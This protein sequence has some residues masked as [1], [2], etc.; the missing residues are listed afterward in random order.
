MGLC[1]NDGMKPDQI[2]ALVREQAPFVFDRMFGAMDK[3]RERMER[4]C[5][6]LTQ[7]NVP[8]AVIGGNAVAAWVATRDEGAV[9]NTKDVD[10]LLSPE[11][12]DAATKALAQVGFHRV[13]TLGVTM[14][15]DGSDGKPSQAVHVIWAGEKVR[16]DYSMAAPT[17]DQ[18]R[19]IDGKRF[20]ELLRLLEMKLVSN[21][22]K[23]RVHVRDM[24]G[25]GL[26]DESWL[27]K[28]NPLLA[29]R[30]QELLDDPDG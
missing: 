21:R 10:I 19:D 3:V 6:A 20:V 17:V 5:G 2:D 28:L 4:A 24:I 12:A 18:S 14:F 11:D 29:Q 13:K 8:Y 26:I 1:Y 7:A 27:E 22:D 16:A 15:L 9:R 25:V 23:D 30:L